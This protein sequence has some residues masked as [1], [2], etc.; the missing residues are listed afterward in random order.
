MA[1]VW[2]DDE[3]EALLDEYLK[4]LRAELRGQKLVKAEAN[5]EVERRTGRT[6][7]SIEFK[8]CNLSAAL[9]DLG[10]PWVKGY[11]PRGN[12][13]ASLS[14]AAE[15]R[16]A[17]KGDISP[18]K[19]PQPRAKAARLASRSDLPSALLA[20]NEAA[21]TDL[22]ML[23]HLW[24]V[25]TG[26]ALV[27][28]APDG[29]IVRLANG[30]AAPGVEAALA[31]FRSR[32]QQALP[33]P[34]MLFLV[35]APGA[36]K[37]HTAASLVQ[38]FKEVG[39]TDDGLA[40]RR[41]DYEAGPARLTVVNDATIPDPRTGEISIST[42]INTAIRDGRHLFA[43]VNRG[44]L[45]QDRAADNGAVND[46][47]G[48]QVVRWL[49]GGQYEGSPDDATQPVRSI[50]TE[51]GVDVLVV[52]LD[53]CSLFEPQPHVEVGESDDKSDV[54]VEQVLPCRIHQRDDL[55]VSD[56][57]ALSVM[58]DTA[59]ELQQDLPYLHPQG[60]IHANLANLADET[61]QRSWATMLRCA[62]LQAAQGFTYRELWGAIARS[63]VGDLPRMID[64][65]SI[66][67]WEQDPGTHDN[68]WELLKSQAALRWPQAMFD[69]SAPTV[70]A[71]RDPV[72]RITWSADPARDARPGNFNP[73]QWD[74][75]WATPVLD[76]FASQSEDQSPLKGLL[77]AL[78]QE[79]PFHKIVQP[80][81]EALDRAYWG[82]SSAKAMQTDRKR[83]DLGAWYGGYLTRLYAASRGI[84]AFLPAVTLWVESWHHGRNL[85][86]ALN[87]R[88]P[89]LLRPQFDPDQPNSPGLL[90]LFAPKTQ[91]L[92]VGHGRPQLAL[93]IASV[94]LR[95][96]PT[97]GQQLSVQLL[98]QGTLVGTLELD[99]VLIREALAYSETG[100]PGLTD[101]TPV[102]APRLERI[103]S[104][105]LASRNLGTVD[106]SVA[107]E[108]TTF[109]IGI[110]P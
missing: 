80:F 99:V 18:V 19:D 87:D 54:H 104:A 100:H 7:G 110:K 12:Y 56:V 43:C 90:P 6:K 37:S 91:P 31:W 63:L 83:A 52:Y 25:A 105:R 86:Q 69:S 2:S 53:M 79:D 8:F 57:P 62:E 106:L 67:K 96:E 24:D 29:D 73:A 98:E 89:P 44:I 60:V 92:T 77:S 38:D 9:D 15:R 97:S 75:G 55:D 102:I 5:R 65:N 85:P 61:L 41:Y 22:A 103:R 95:C 82:R 10:Y 45:V 17:Q 48:A 74:S 51:S 20:G 36:G 94:E 23:P 109:Q 50:V 16:L 107:M 72:G 32:L 84:T 42:D 4:L 66:T 13:Q 101:L 1:G 70:R 14:T 40:N 3:I 26:G 93:R 71:G 78:P 11:K 108:D 35:G 34:A 59:R 58:A 88:L 47:E 46:S 21:A 30:P 33:S 68:E 28:A 64:R 76:A 39:G 81:D 49:M 27:A